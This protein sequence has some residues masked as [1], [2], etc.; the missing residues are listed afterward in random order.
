MIPRRYVCS[1]CSQRFEFNQREAVYHLSP[2]ALGAQVADS[3]LHPVP[4]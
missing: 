3:A 1:G 4:V 2:D